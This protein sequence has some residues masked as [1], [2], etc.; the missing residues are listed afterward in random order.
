MAIRSNLINLQHKCLI[1]TDS[2]TSWE[3]VLEAL[4]I[5]PATGTTDA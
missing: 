5:A 4:F 2:S 3:Q 1:G